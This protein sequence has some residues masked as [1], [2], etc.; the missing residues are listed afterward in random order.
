MK[1]LLTST[2]HSLSSLMNISRRRGS[3][4]D[5]YR[6]ATTT[7]IC[8]YLQ[9]NLNH[10]YKSATT[11]P[12]TYECYIQQRL[13]DT[14]VLYT[15]DLNFCIRIRTVSLNGHITTYKT[16]SLP[17]LIQYVGLRRWLMRENR[18]AFRNR[19]VYMSCLFSLVPI[20]LLLNTWY[21]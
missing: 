7:D 11:W 2:N 10:N 13:S 18:M 21:A 15:F 12:S 16:S 19:G 9:A 5:E 14:Y 4:L 20:V 3:F 17:A 1:D 6:F 8:N